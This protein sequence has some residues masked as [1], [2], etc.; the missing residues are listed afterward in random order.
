MIQLTQDDLSRLGYRAEESCWFHSQSGVLMKGFESIHEAAISAAHD[1]NE[2]FAG[3]LYRC[4]FCTH[5]YHSG[6]PGAFIRPEQ[7]DN[8]ADKPFCMCPKCSRFNHPLEPAKGL[9][10]HH[11][12]LLEN[13]E[14]FDVNQK[15]VLES[16]NR[17]DHLV[18]SKDDVPGCG[19]TLLKF[20]L[21][22]LSVAE[23]CVDHKT[24][25]R[26]LETAIDQLSQV[27]RAFEQKAL[28]PA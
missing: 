26:R 2:R 24:A 11:E 10:A 25:I 8:G 4:R 1:A 27:K 9:L 13:I 22:E 17:G 21:A 6:T 5:A 15:I 18:S 12:V 23:D 14:S 3:D 16:Y 28:E 20:L 7:A 19:D